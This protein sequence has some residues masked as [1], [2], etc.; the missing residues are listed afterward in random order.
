MA[1]MTEWVT[2]AAAE[3]HG[4]AATALRHL[5]LLAQSSGGQ[6]QHLGTDAHKCSEALDAALAAMCG[7]I[8]ARAM[9]LHSLA[10]Q[11]GRLEIVERE[12]RKGW[13]DARLSSAWKTWKACV[14]LDAIR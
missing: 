1:E 10:L 7:G 2:S 6:G 8:Q 9:R 5:Q 3:L 4:Q 13:R 11:E 12:V 14:T